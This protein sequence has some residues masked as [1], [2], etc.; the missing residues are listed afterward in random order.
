MT[1]GS[2]STVSDMMSVI[3]DPPLEERIWK[4][5]I[6]HP[7][8]V[9]PGTVCSHQTLIRFLC[10]GNVLSWN[11]PHEVGIEVIQVM[12]HKNGGCQYPH[13]I[14]YPG[15]LGGEALVGKKGLLYEG[16]P[17]DP[18]TWFTLFLHG[19]LWDSPNRHVTQVGGGGGFINLLILLEIMTLLDNLTR[20]LKIQWFIPKYHTSIS[21]YYYLKISSVYHNLAIS[22]LTSLTLTTFF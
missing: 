8:C 22:S 15:N 4:Y 12:P 3:L 6:V 7:V 11:T 21:L 10:L 5:F 17:I 1:M 18:P 13:M 14:E 20:V 9:D 16:F 19:I 2:H